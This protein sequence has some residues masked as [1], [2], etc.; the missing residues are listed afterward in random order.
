MKIRW[1]KLLFLAFGCLAMSNA[2][3]AAMPNF[4]VPTAWRNVAS[5]LE[6][7]TISNFADFPGGNLHVFKIDLQHYNLR[8]GLTKNA[9]GG[10]KTL[11]QLMREENA[12]IAVNGGFFSPD[13]KPLGLLVSQGKLLNSLRPTS[14]WGIFSIHGTQAQ[15]TARKDYQFDA[16]TDFAIQAGPRLVV[17][18]QIPNIASNVD[19]RTALGIT[20]DGRVIIAVTENLMLTTQEL[21][22]IMRRPENMGGLGCVNAL[23]LDGGHSTQMYTRLATLLLQVPSFTQVA[24]SILVVPR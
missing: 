5:G 12:I 6:Y 9:D 17:N 20:K 1:K 22:E 11:Q 13:D 10:N 15:I 2:A 3:V 14:W 4:I 8:I 7:T 24:D 18:E 19:Y 16:T 21:A 23:N